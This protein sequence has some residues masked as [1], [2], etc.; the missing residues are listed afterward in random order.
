MAADEVGVNIVLADT[1]WILERLAREIAERHDYVTISEHA[2]PTAGLRYYLNYSAWRERLPGVDVGYFTH[3]ED[4]A[5]AEARFFEVAVNVDHC[6]CHS[7]R[8]EARLREHSVDAVTTISPGVDLTRFKPVVKVGVVGRTYATG[9]KGETLVDA[10]LDMPGIEWHFTGTGWPRPAEV[11]D[12]DAMPGFYNAMDYILVPSLYEGGPMSVAE[13]IACGTPVIAPSVGWVDEFPHRPFVAGDIDDLRR[14]L[15][16]VVAERAGDQALVEGRS[17]ANWADAHDRL[18][19]DLLAGRGQVPVKLP[20]PLPGPVVLALHGHEALAGGGPSVRVPRTAEALRALG[21]SASARTFPDP[22]IAAAG[23]VHGFNLWEPSGALALADF[24]RSRAKPFVFSPI[25]LDQREHALWHGIVPEAARAARDRDELAALIGAAKTAIA[26]GK[27][28]GPTQAMPGYDA[29]TRALVGR[30]DAVIY[31]SE[32]ERALVEDAGSIARASAVVRNPVDAARYT[33][34][35]GSA[36]EALA[37]VRDYVLC[38]GRLEPRKNQAM[39]L[40]ALRDLNL[41]IVLA[42]AASDAHYADLV[43]MLKTDNVRLVGRIDPTG[44]LMP[45]AYAGAR[46]VVQPSWAEG[47]PLAALEAAAAGAALVLSDRSSEREYFGDYAR[48]CDPS[49]PVAMRNTILDA[50]DSERSKADRRTLQELARERHSYARHARETLAVYRQAWSAYTPPAATP[51]VVIPTGR[52]NR[53]IVDLTDLVYRRYANTTTAG[54]RAVART[55]VE[56]PACEAQLIAWNRANGRFVQIDPSALDQTDLGAYVEF[57]ARSGRYPA[58]FA[59]E[60]RLLVMGDFWIDDGRYQRDLV[61]FADAGG[62]EIALSLNSVAM[63]LS[64]SFETMLTAARHLFVPTV[65]TRDALE[66]LAAKTVM[67]PFSARVVRAGDRVV[68]LLDTDRS[69]AASPPKGL[70]VLAVALDGIGDAERLLARMWEGIVDEYALVLAT[71][72][73][74]PIDPAALGV[75]TQVLGDLGQRDFDAL[76]SAATLVVLPPNR[77]DNCRVITEALARGKICIAPANPGAAETSDLVDLIDPLDLPGWIARLR[78]YLRSASARTARE[79][80]I[81]AAFV[82]TDWSLTAR[83]LRTMLT[84][85]VSASR[86]TYTIGL[87]AMLI[88]RPGAVCKRAGWHASEAWGCW[89]S[90]RTSSFGFVLPE[91]VDHDLALM[92]ELRS[93]LTA[94]QSNACDVIVNGVATDRIILRGPEWRLFRVGIPAHM[95]AAAR[96]ITVEI[97]GSRLIELSTVFPDELAGRRGGIAVAFVALVD[98]RFPIVSADYAIHPEAMRGAIAIGETVDLVRDSRTVA[99]LPERSIVGSD[100]GARH[101]DHRPQ[102][103][104]KLP[105][106]AAGLRVT[107]RYRAVATA[108]APLDATVTTREGVVLGRIIATDD[109]IHEAVLHVPAG[110]AIQPLLLEFLGA[111]KRSPHRFGVGLRQEAFG[112]GFFGLTV[113]AVGAPAPGRR[114][115]GLYALGDMIVFGT[116][117]AMPGHSTATAF[118]DLSTWHEREAMGMWT[119]GTAGRVALKLAR[120]PAAS[121]HLRI[122]ASCAVDPDAIEAIVRV[123]G[124]TI[125]TQTRWDAG[126][127]TMMMTIDPALVDED[128]ALAI[129]LGVDR[130]VVPSLAG[131]WIDDRRLGLFVHSLVVADDPDGLRGSEVSDFQPWIEPAPDED[132][133]EPVNA[134]PLLAEPDILDFE[135]P[136]DPATMIDEADLLVDAADEADA[137]DDADIAEEEREK[138]E[139]EKDEAATPNGFDAPIADET[140]LPGNPQQ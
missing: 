57:A 18:F 27:G 8:Y 29:A 78:Y 116:Y 49:D 80:Q 123:G 59:A 125:A 81:A 98:A 13:A 100:W 87:Q 42:G 108:E 32:H 139:E 79:A 46:L 93:P 76:L 103:Q 107:L 21:V 19:R 31:L 36:F 83:T 99:I 44:P 6:V 66:L 77:G 91:P 136:D 53:I 118:L 133:F 102:L 65:A 67:P 61:T 47:A 86:G 50:Y 89:S 117:D 88:D 104:L 106:A 23:L 74:S 127:F 115:D 120:R 62:L 69:T 52:K 22:A 134:E 105:A 20:P 95:I 97:R 25:Y 72:H 48:Y 56:Y 90:A 60:S 92:I 35:D 45:S 58:D 63:P 122:D 71:A 130:P 126:R 33:R 55:L 114:P 64:G 16:E 113:E 140:S 2:D 24:A 12:D 41:P 138:E 111:E 39:L 75:G 119:Q 37:G 137:D 109:A 7:A 121:L 14:V 135:L 112:I 17:W 110:L 82:A 1:G 132:A 34:C 4:D 5:G 129:E 26:R 40:H 124:E 15:T 38:V 28:T 128:G 11:L 131:A 96:E 43:A 30:A 94:R 10:V 101:A 3:V 9:R 70:F 85:E 54:L 73:A 84:E 51:V 68:D